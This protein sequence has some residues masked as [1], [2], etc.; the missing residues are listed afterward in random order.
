VVAVTVVPEVGDFRRFAN[1]RQLM[2]S[3]FYLTSPHTSSLLGDWR[4]LDATYTILS[5]TLSSLILTE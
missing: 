1:P 4:V 2:A 3:W 5:R